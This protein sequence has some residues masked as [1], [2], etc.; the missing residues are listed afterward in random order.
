M[1]TSKFN[2]TDKNANEVGY[3]LSFA[4]KYSKTRVYMVAYCPHV[5]AF[6]ALKSNK[7][8]LLLYGFC[9]Y[10]LSLRS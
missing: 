6:Y 10:I 8:I 7:S 5:N 1:F 4:S 2:F 3:V 9:I